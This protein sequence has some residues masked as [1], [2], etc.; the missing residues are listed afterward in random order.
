MQSTKGLILFGDI[1]K[2][3]IYSVYVDIHD[4]QQ[5]RR[6]IPFHT[7]QQLKKFRT[8]LIDCKKHY[9]EITNSEFK[10]F[11]KDK[12]YEDF[13]KNFTHDN[14]EFNKLNF[15][16]LYLFEKLAQDYDEVLYLDF[17]VVPKTNDSIFEVTD[18]I[19]V[20]AVDATK[21]N[22]WPE[23]M[24][25]AGQKYEDNVKRLDGYHW[26]TKAMCKQAMLSIDMT[27]PLNYLISNTAILLGQ[28]QE[29]KKLQFFTR[30]NEMM[31]KFAQVKIENLYGKVLTDMF[32][33]NNEVFF[34]YLLENYHID[35]HNLSNQWHYIQLKNYKNSIDVSEAK[36]IHAIDKDF[37]K[38]FDV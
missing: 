32:F 38:I 25:V 35:W 3:I 29:I 18:K 8:K 7:Q 6:D 14:W 31:N 11:A 27:S 17:D 36:F 9:A 20:H 12:I 24:L 4:L 21:E 30:M 19:A 22:T 15:Y 10:L 5:D 28:K 23:K 37:G 33:V 26:Y 16:K 34:T 13:L 2:R 1:M